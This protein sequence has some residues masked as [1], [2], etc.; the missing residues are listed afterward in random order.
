MGA[1]AE[2]GM[3]V[4]R[5]KWGDVLDDVDGFL[6]RSDCFTDER[7]RFGLVGRACSAICNEEVGRICICSYQR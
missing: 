3:V 5:G 2:I 6:C 7:E 1:E 4:M